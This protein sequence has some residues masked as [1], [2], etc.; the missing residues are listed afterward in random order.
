M[1]SR[2][3]IG[4]SSRTDSEIHGPYILQICK[5]ARI[6]EDGLD[7]WSVNFVLT[8]EVWSGVLKASNMSGDAVDVD[9][10]GQIQVFHLSSQDSVIVVKSAD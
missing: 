4:D 6:A 10:N 1:H 5:T 9:V 3:V 7:A 8:S 2:D